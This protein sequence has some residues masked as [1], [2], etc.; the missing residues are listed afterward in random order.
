VV[1]MIFD[2]HVH[3]SYSDG[4]ASPEEII[5]HAKGMGIGGIAIT[6]HDE[7]AGALSALKLDLGDFVIIPGIEVSSLDGHILGLG[8]KELIPRD[9]SAEETVD[10]IHE[11]GGVAIAAH[12]YDKIRKGV[13]DLIYKVKFDAAEVYNGHTIMSSRKPEDVLGSLTIPAVGGSDA[14]LLSELGAVT[15]EF[16]GDPLDDIIKGRGK[17]SVNISKTKILINH[18]NRRLIRRR[19]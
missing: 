12:P 6:D 8:I 15:M 19:T 4:A 14:H 10:R 7:V 3:S 13:G 1:K 18:L 17:I 11:L 9:L 5:Q 2:L 16:S